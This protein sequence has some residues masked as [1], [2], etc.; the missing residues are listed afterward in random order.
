[1]P[2]YANF[3]KD[4]VT[5]K[6]LINFETTK[7]TH[8]MSEIVHSMAPKLE[9]PDAFTIFCAIGSADFSKALCDL[10]ESINLMPYS[11]FKALGIGKPRPTYMRL[12]MADH[13]MKRPLGVTEDVRP[14]LAVGKALC[15]VKAGEFTFWVGDEQEV[16]HVCKSMRQSNNN[17]MCSFVDLVTDVI[18]DDASA[19]INVG[20]MLEAVL[21]NLD[22]DEMDGFM[23]CVNSLQGIGSYNYAPRKLY[24]DLE[25]K[26]ALPT[27]PSIEDP[28]NLELKPLPPYL[29]YECFGPYSTLPVILSSCLIKVQV[30]STLAVLQKRNKAIGWNLTDIRV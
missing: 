29:R 12:Q 13:T 7:V 11:V 21:L 23:E 18:T 26:K 1:M 10:R 3:M 8:Q 5:K 28:P 2:G 22:D 6:R 19:T 30:D 14:F 9:D 27:K 24:L 17:E 16:F 15:N 20:D 25:N 4:L